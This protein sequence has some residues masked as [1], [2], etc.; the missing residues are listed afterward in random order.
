MKRKY[1]NVIVVLVMLFQAFMPSFMYVE[2]AEEKPEI[3]TW[4]SEMMSE[5]FNFQREIK[6]ALLWS[7]IDERRYNASAWRWWLFTNWILKLPSAL[8]FMASNVRWNAR[9]SFSTATT[10]MVLLLFASASVLRSNTEGLA[11]L[12]KDRPIVR[13]Y[14]ELLDIETEL[15][16]LAYYSSK[17]VNLLNKLEWD[18]AE[19]INKVIKK[20]QKSWLLKDTKR[21]ISSDETM[22]D[23]LLEMLQMNTVME[24]FILYPGPSSLLGYSWCFS[25]SIT[26]ND[27]NAIL[28]FSEKA[29]EELDEAYSWMWEFGKCNL[30][31]S[32]FKST[33]SKAFGNNIDNLDASFSDVKDAAK[34]LTSLFTPSKSSDKKSSWKKWRCD[35][36]DYEMA[37]LRAY[38]WAGWTC[39]E[40]LVDAQFDSSQVRELLWDKKVQKE[41]REKKGNL[42]KTDIVSTTIDTVSNMLAWV[43]EKE[44]WWNTS[45]GVNNYNV[46]FLDD[47]NEDFSSW[48]KTL[49]IEYE[50]S[51]NDAI[52][53]DLSYEL[54]K[55]RWLLDMLD[56]SSDSAELLRTELKKIADYQCAS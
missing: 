43:R 47:M 19:N 11:I 46:Q 32:N 52:S 6:S 3:C 39:N 30:Y 1:I 44:R 4:P 51:Q 2:A 37:Q 26:C 54:S 15:F 18:V 9:S 56:S 29:V 22:T 12:F 28:M 13:D 38:W 34:R 24:H 33:I 14:K 45:Y 53:S 16:D 8:D 20:Y 25:S 10:S 17:Q 27:I 55:I 21:G 49:S 23:I 48:Y 41:Q 7:E 50:Q 42:I 35:L 31:W 5:Y 40:W 36:S